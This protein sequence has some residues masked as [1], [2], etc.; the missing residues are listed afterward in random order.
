MAKDKIKGITVAIG[1]DTAGLQKALG[2]VNS[3]AG[4]L[5]SELRQVENALKLDPENTVLLAQKQEILAEQVENTSKKLQTL[6]SMQERVDE[7]YKK[8]N[9]GSDAYR[10]FQRE[11]ATTESTLTKLKSQQDKV[12]N[13]TDKAADSTEDL[14]K[15]ENKL[16]NA[17]ESASNSTEDLSK[18]QKRLDESTDSK[19]N[20]KRKVMKQKAVPLI[21]I[22]HYLC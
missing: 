1:G 4:Q 14:T 15:Q 20:S 16:S 8:G 10:A 13:S 18:E 12:S 3:K 5:R 2:E 9:I 17:N 21:L 11:I 19:I 6:K 22:K 7:E